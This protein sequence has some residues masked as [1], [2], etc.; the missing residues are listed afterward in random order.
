VDGMAMEGMINTG[1]DEEMRQ[2]L[3]EALREP[4]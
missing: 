4:R 2:T 3:Q 1:D